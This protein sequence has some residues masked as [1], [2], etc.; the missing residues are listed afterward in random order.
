M[1]GRDVVSQVENVL[2]CGDDYKLCDF[3]SCTTE[4]LKT[5]SVMSCHVMIIHAEQIKRISIMC[6]LSVLFDS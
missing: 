2:C 5:S 3:G 6:I 4:F 1:Y